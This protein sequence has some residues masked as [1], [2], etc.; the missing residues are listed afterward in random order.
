MST[1]NSLSPRIATFNWFGETPAQNTTTNE[2]GAVVFT[3][4]YGDKCTYKCGIE[5]PD[6]GQRSCMDDSWNEEPCVF[7]KSS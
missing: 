1:S 2:N 7:L 4:I 5:A 3:A 6:L